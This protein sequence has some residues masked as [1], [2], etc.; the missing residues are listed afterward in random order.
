MAAVLFTD[1][2]QICFD[3]DITTIIREILKTNINA[4]ILIIFKK[5]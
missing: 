1:A 3:H 4:Q 5:R 2:E